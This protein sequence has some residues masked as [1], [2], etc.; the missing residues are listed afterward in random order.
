MHWHINDLLGAGLLQTR[1][2]EI[3]NQFRFWNHRCKS[4]CV[5]G[6]NGICPHRKTAD[7]LFGFEMDGA[8]EAELRSHSPWRTDDE[9]PRTMNRPSQSGI[10]QNSR[11][12][13]STT[14]ATPTIR[15]SPCCDMENNKNSSS[16]LPFSNS[17]TASKTTREA[18]TKTQNKTQ[19]KRKKQ[20]HKYYTPEEEI[21]SPPPLR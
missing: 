1:D 12:A 16:R 9:T 6:T 10:Q 3:I 13:L 4:L 20:N 5:Q 15:K 7:W 2:L 11:T 18:T 14:H 19:Q 21:L 17:K 8:L